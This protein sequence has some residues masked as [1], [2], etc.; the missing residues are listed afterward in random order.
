MSNYI[1]FQ[2]IFIK[3][4]II[5]SQMFFCLGVFIVF[6]V[7]D[8]QKKALGG[9]MAVLCSRTRTIAAAGMP[10][11]GSDGLPNASRQREAWL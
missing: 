8:T 7:L 11:D 3:L 6:S 2:K 5:C 10:V 1:E 9:L 4:S